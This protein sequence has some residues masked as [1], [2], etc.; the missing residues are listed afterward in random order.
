MNVSS[1]PLSLYGQVGFQLHINKVLMSHSKVAVVLGQFVDQQEG[2]HKKNSDKN[3]K[4]PLTAVR[5]SRSDIVISTVDQSRA[6]DR[7]DPEKGR[8]AV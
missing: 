7:Q 4:I 8:P 2:N 1:Q 6:E 5:R 3:N